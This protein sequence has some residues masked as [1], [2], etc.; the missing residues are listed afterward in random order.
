MKKVLITGISSGL[1]KYLTGALI[2]DGFRVIGIDNVYPETFKKEIDDKAL[3]FYEQDLS[4][5]DE[6]INLL[7]KITS[8]Q[9]RIEVLINNAA[10]LN[11]KFF[12]DYNYV[13][14]IQ[15]LKVNLISPIVISKYFLEHMLNKN[16]GR[17]INISSVSAFSGKDTTSI[18]AASKS[19]INRFHQVLTTEMRL[20]KDK[21]NV[22][23]NT[24]CPDRIALPEFLEENP[25]INTRA[26][27]KPEKIYYFILKIINSK[28]H[29]KVY[30]I[31][32]FNWGRLISDIQVIKKIPL[33]N[34]LQKI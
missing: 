9:G 1:G 2:K 13:E 7:H 3:F 28:V 26:L 15:K 18:Y 31:P 8:D 24:I 20:L 16:Y 10:I 6:T 11:F 32:V 5:I 27:I 33:L 4:K 25:D 34:R 21:T 19:G 23:L 17:I 14:I 29:G 22:T 30:V 12:S